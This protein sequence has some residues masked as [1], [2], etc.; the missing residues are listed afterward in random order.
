MTR[1]NSK[2]DPLM[3][4]ARAFNAPLRK[5]LLLAVGVFFDRI[6]AMVLIQ[7]KYCNPT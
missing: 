1:F 2:S 7:F 3:K 4:M 6:L 5:R